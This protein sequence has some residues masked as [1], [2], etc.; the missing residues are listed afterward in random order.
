L[1]N[2]LRIFASIGKFLSRE[3]AAALPVFLFFVVGFLLLLLF[4][5]L[6]LA[7]FSIEMTALSKAVIGAL[8]AA[9]A[10]LI[11]DETPLARRLEHRRRIVAV[12]VKTFF[13]GAITLLLGCLERFLDALRRVDS[14]DATIRYMIDQANMY[15][16]LSWVLGVSL[17]F[18]LYFALFEIEKRMG[19]GELWKLFFDSPETVGDS[20]LRSSASAGNRRG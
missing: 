2:T 18:A 12:A 8:F 10:V 3:F 13:Y 7:N 20:S 9:K 11:L 17:V 15:R 19:E 14:F 5:K 6:A 4:I 1:D 16:M